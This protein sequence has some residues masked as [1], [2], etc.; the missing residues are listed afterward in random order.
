MLSVHPPVAKQ[1]AHKMWAATENQN[2]I[3]LVFGTLKYTEVKHVK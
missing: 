1:L 3:W 2:S